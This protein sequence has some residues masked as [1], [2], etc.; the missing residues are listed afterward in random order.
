MGA[1]PAPTQHRSRAERGATNGVRSGQNGGEGG[2]SQRCGMFAL[3]CIR[4]ST[5]QFPHRKSLEG[6]AGDNLSSERCPPKECL[7]QIKQ[8][9]I[10]GAKAYK[11]NVQKFRG[12]LFKGRRYSHAYSFFGVLAV[13]VPL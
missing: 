11:S 7:P 12:A 1:Q 2:I 10:F 4:K 9:T 13:T 6:G 3:V 8:N 5:L